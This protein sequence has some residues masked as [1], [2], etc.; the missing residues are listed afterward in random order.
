M[1][2]HNHQATHNRLY[3]R[4]PL[5]SRPG[6]PAKINPRSQHLSAPAVAE[7]V[8]DSLS[9]SDAAADLLPEHLV[10]P[11]RTHNCGQLRE[12][13][14]GQQVA[15]CGWIDRNRDLGGVQFIDLRDHTGIMQV[16]GAMS[17]CMGLECGLR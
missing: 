7:N 17:T 3:S 12:P 5:P 13:D 14:V 11:G 6:A 15:L 2:L 1:R 9:S 4:L 16:R 10:W 8:V